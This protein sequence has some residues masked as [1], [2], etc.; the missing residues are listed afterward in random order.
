MTLYCTSGLEHWPTFCFST[1]KTDSKQ[2]ETDRQTDREATQ[3]GRSVV[4]LVVNNWCL[5]WKFASRV[6]HVADCWDAPTTHHH[7][8][9]PHTQ[10]ATHDQSTVIQLIDARL[11]TL[12]D[13]WPGRCGSL[14]STWARALLTAAAVSAIASP[15]T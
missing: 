4:L 2:T 15:P 8:S 1:A 10:R 12:R 5:R 11:I 14:E 3:M 13:T 6:T 9:R 7:P